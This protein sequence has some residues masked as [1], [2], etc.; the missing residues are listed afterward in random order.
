MKRLT[1]NGEFVS[2]KD[3]TP[4][5]LE[6]IEKKLNLGWKYSNKKT[7]KSWKKNEGVADIIIKEEKK[8]KKEKVKKE[9]KPQKE[10]K[11]KKEKP[12]DKKDK[13]KK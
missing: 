4:Q 3:A 6:E 8:E 1:K 7:W 2:M 12:K 9:V 11:Q 5:D 10:V 13:K